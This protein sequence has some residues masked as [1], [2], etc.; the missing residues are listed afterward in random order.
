MLDS[1]CYFLLITP[2]Y[3]KDKREG[4]RILLSASL[5]GYYSG[6]PREGRHPQSHPRA[7][8]PQLPGRAYSQPAGRD[9]SPGGSPRLTALPTP[10]PGA[11]D[12]RVAGGGREKTRLS[13]HPAHPGT[14]RAP[15]SPPPP[16]S[17]LGDSQ[18]PGKGTF[19]AVAPP[20][21]RFTAPAVGAGYIFCLI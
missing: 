15:T 1:T 18:T 4:D 12:R 3:H 7:G 17:S 19:P 14:R 16:P 13:P 8:R 21:P 2:T 9:R 5:L 20:A 11:P 6:P 10:R